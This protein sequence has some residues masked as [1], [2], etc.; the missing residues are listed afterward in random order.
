MTGSSSAMMSRSREARLV[1]S[2]RG[3][4]LARRQEPSCANPLG[5]GMMQ[6][7]CNKADQRPRTVRR[8]VG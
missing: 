8:A 3:A 7:L 6:L 2:S 5:N 1:T 4:N